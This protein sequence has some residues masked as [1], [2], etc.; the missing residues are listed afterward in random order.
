MNIEFLLAVSFGFGV[1]SFA[2]LALQSS[3]STLFSRVS[4][5]ATAS[6]PASGSLIRSVKLLMNQFRSD[7]SA[8]LERALFELPELIDLI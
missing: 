2:T 1:A 4:A 7:T 3:N 5:V 6:Q 8:K